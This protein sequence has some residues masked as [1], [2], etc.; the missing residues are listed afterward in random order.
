MLS[1]FHCA[2]WQCKV[3][4]AFLNF[5]KGDYK[6]LERCL[7]CVECVGFGF[8]LPLF[9]MERVAETPGFIRKSI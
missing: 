8:G 6:T 4:S 3:C 5:I 9:M 7:S 2:F 1:T